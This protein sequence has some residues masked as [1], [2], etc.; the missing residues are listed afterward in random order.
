METISFGF[1]QTSSMISPLAWILT[2]IERKILI[3][4]FNLHRKVWVSGNWVRDINV[5]V[6]D[7][8]LR[9][10]HGFW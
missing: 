8:Q 5:K 3:R 6:K 7:C 1:T 9:G 4:K 2:F 10:S